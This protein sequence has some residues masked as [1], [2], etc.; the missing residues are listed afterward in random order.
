LAGLAEL[1]E[2]LL[3]SIHIAVFDSVIDVGI[4]RKLTANSANPASS[5]NSAKIET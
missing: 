4:V 5:A 2:E 1:A 3:C